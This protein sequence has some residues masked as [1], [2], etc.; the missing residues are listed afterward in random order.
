MDKIDKIFKAFDKDGN[1]TLDKQEAREL[2]KQIQ[3]I[4]HKDGH[5]FSVNESMIDNL[6]KLGDTNGD[7]VISKQEFTNLLKKFV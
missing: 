6:F 5:T 2:L 3:K 1:N 7:G 4:M